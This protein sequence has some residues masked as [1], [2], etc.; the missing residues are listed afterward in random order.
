MGIGLAL[1]S[2]CGGTT[3]HGPSS[4]DEGSTISGG[5]GASSHAGT[6]VTGGKSVGGSSAFGGTSGRSNA[7]GTAAGGKIP[8]PIVTAGVGGQD[9]LLTCSNPYTGPTGGPRI[10]GPESTGSC[11]GIDDATLIARYDD[12]KARVPQGLYY[13][14]E[15]P[16]QRWELPCSMSEAETAARGSKLQLGTAKATFKTDWFYEAEFCSMNERLVYRNLRCDYFDG[17]TL[18]DPSPENLAFLGSLLWWAD[19]WNLS[20]A[21]VLGY[22]VTIGN[23]TDWV[24][25]CALETNHGDFGLCDEVRLQRTQHRV[26]FGG[27]VTLGMPELMRTAKGKCR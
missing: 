26:R 8:D 21:A 3:R 14:A 24:E 10:D 27:E 12:F 23:A 25:M 1:A 22:A 7:A 13:E 2:A 19:N 11:A 16:S 9:A 5:V 15:S 4:D 20:G 17:T 18:A 6:G